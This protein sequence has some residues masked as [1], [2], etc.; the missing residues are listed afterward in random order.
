MGE[1]EYELSI[2][3]LFDMADANKDGWINRVEFYEA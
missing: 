2:H 1:E 3:A